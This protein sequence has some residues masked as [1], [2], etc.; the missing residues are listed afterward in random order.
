M[1]T[2]A[3]GDVHGNLVALEDLLSKVVDEM[4]ED[5]ELVFLGDYIDRGPHSRQC[6]DRILELQRDAPFA[7][8]TLLG[9]HE[10]WMLR[11]LDDTRRHS[12]VLGMEA[13]D[14]ISSYSTNAAAELSHELRK[15]GPMLVTEQVPAPYELFFSVVPEDHLKFFQ[16]LR[17]HYR[18]EHAVF[19][20]GGL[21]PLAGPIESQDAE[22]LLWGTED[23]PA[24]YCEDEIVVYGHW[25]NADLDQQGWPRPHEENDTY[26]I[27]TISHGVLTAIRFPG[28][29]VF[30]SRRFKAIGTEG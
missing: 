6:V 19:S 10:D 11:S 4:D 18:S 2:I 23:F 1:A 9:N 27:D 3:I 15:L 12:W 20:H 24:A 17:T 26:G 5:D 16:A 29:E 30:Q 14:T 8:I 7:V 25:N 22:S 28:A 13:M 21:D